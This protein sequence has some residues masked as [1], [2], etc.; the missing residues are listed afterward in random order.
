M[1]LKTFITT[2]Q[3]G[4]AKRLAAALGFS[5]SYLSQL[6]VTEALRKPELCVQIERLTLGMVPRQHLR[7][8]WRDIWPE[9][10]DLPEQ[11]SAA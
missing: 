7:S 10:P 9:L 8:N 11:K 4:T 5:A 3:R 2:S 6:A 1:D